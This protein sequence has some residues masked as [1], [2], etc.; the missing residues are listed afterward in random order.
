MDEVELDVEG[1]APR[2][3][4]TAN[5]AM[6]LYINLDGHLELKKT[7]DDYGTFT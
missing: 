2:V 1:I 3:E 6:L 5:N 4:Y 7:T